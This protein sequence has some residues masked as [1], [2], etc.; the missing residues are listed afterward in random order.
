MCLV[1]SP[2][3][4]GG[5]RCAECLTIVSRAVGWD[6]DRTDYDAST[7]SRRW[8]AYWF[9]CRSERHGVWSVQKK[10]STHVSLTVAMADGE[11]VRID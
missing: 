8:A 7:I 4:D 9:V 1:K 2:M 10:M 6:S 3:C 11:G 5:L